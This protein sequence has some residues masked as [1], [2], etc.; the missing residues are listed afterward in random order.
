MRLK[1]EGP[2]LFR[3]NIVFSILSSKPIQISKIRHTSENP[4]TCTRETN[5]SKSSFNCVW[6]LSLEV[7]LGCI[8]NSNTQNSKIQTHKWKYYC[9]FLLGG[10]FLVDFSLGIK[11]TPSFRFEGVNDAEVN[12]L[13]LMEVVTNGSKFV[14]NETGTSIK[15]NPGFI[16]T[17][18]SEPRISWEVV[19]K[20]ELG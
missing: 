4:V 1:F 13:R 9:N 8:Q 18:W 6:D 19:R 17:F 2:S 11:T 16:V 14:I 10:V 20:V 3:E 7:R 15:F 12:F 5:C